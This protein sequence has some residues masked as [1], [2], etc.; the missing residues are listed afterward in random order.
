MN[1][2][3]HTLLASA[4]L[5]LHAGTPARAQDAPPAPVPKVAF[6]EVRADSLKR[7][8][9]P[10]EAPSFEIRSHTET[11][12][13]VKLPLAD[14]DPASVDESTPVGVSVGGF[15]HEAT[16]GDSHNWRNG[17]NRAKFPVLV[18]TDNVD[19]EGN[20]IQKRVGTVIY[21]W[22]DRKLVVAVTGRG[23]GSVV[24]D[25][26]EDFFTDAEGS[27]V[28]FLEPIDVSVSFGEQLGEASLFANGVARKVTK[29]KGRGDAAESFDLYFLTAVSYYDTAPPEVDLIDPAE[30]A[31]VDSE[32]PT[33]TGEVKDNV[34]AASSLTV[35]KVLLNGVDVTEQV[36]AEFTD[37]DNT[38]APP[39][40]GQIVV[41][42][43]ELTVRENTLKFSVTDSSGNTTVVTRH[44]TYTGGAA[45][46]TTAPVVSI[47]DP[48]EG[49]VV[50]FDTLSISGTATDNLDDASSLEVTHV[51]INGVNVT[52]DVV[53]VFEDGDSTVVPAVPGSVIVENL[54]LAEGVNTIV[55]AVSDQAGNKTV[56]TRHVTYL[57]QS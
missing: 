34:D 16:L 19:D 7:V 30:G 3:P 51:L 43:I 40:P 55:I 45:P 53:W 50:T 22:S 38:V 37:Q 28:R 2:A 35:S 48:V 52:A 1:H 42:G 36:S 33:F 24:A 29:T 11:T 47:D 12:I 15:F 18:D 13:L 20:P 46:D 27:K 23:I 49:A 8:E 25:S 57:L 14:F 6:T 39:V 21:T 9:S 5:L 56:V 54:I 10:G 17:R 32:F 41:D 44:I 31:E 4:L 26:A